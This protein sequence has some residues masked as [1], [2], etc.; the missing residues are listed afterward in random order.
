MAPRRRG[1]A[2]YHGPMLIERAHGAT[3]II[4]PIIVA[5]SIIVG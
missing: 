1:S 4:W 2:N 3:A 5:G